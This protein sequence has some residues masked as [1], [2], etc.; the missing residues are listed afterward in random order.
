LVQIIDEAADVLTTPDGAESLSRMPTKVN[1]LWPKPRLL[2][3]CFGVKD[4]GISLQL[5]LAGFLQPKVN[6]AIQVSVT[7]FAAGSGCSTVPGTRYL[8][9]WFRQT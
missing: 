3:A 1:S 9:R 8:R 4:D 6:T 7:F 5:R 2:I